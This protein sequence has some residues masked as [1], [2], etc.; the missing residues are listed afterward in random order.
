MRKKTKTV[1]AAAAG[2]GKQ[3]Y[4]KREDYWERFLSAA[5]DICVMLSPMMV[6]NIIMLAVLG[7]ML[8]IAGIF[9][10]DLLVAV[11]MI[12]SIFFF[13]MAVMAKTKGRSFGMYHFGFVILRKNG[14][15]AKVSLCILRDLLGN[16]LPFMIL[17]VFTNLLGVGIYWFLNVLLFCADK[18]HRALIDIVLGTY[19]ARLPEKKEERPV[20]R[21]EVLPAAKKQEPAVQSYPRNQIDLR[22]RSNFSV[23]GEFNVE[24]LFQMAARNGIHTISITDW[25]SAK[26]NVLAARMSELYKVNYVPGIELGAEYK[27][28]RVCVLGYFIDHTSDLYTTIENNSLLS[29]RNASIERVRKFERF[30]KKQIPI[31]ELL[32]SNRFQRIS[33]KM[34]ARYVLKSPVYDDCEILK[35]YRALN[36]NTGAEQIHK[37]YFT[38]GKPC[39]V[40]LKCPPLQ[41]IL[42][43]ISL[44]GGI[45]VLAD[46]AAFLKEER[47]LAEILDMG[48]E[49]VQVFQPEY[50]KAIMAALLKEAQKRK[51]LITCGSGFSQSGK[52][53]EI[54]ECH[55]PAEGESMVS[56]LIRARM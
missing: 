21:E 42:D 38:Y 2:G 54:G 7:S 55:C 28:R 3:Y 32:H 1:N 56:M 27:G 35:P 25:N 20:L 47:L 48:I 49:G 53:V 34:I 17:M 46:A 9:V 24:E 23:N 26:A 43:V 19:V 51:L 52:G 6:W 40:M 8:S 11:L 22:L 50:D 45:V 44:S 5:L 39:Y 33:G 14:K 12:F 13:N 29:E 16:S 4:L 41:D 15:R 10:A 30:L 37:D 36:L 31:E 18:K